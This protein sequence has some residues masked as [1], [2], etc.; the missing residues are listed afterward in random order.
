MVEQIIWRFV[1]INLF[2]PIFQ[3]YSKEYFQAK[4]GRKIRNI[5]LGPEKT[6]FLYKKE[7]N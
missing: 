5:Q 1:G 2:I 4:I 6:L 3:E 7:C